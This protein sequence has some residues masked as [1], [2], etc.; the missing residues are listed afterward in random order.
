[1]P[2]SASSGDEPGSPRPPRVAL[3]GQDP[4]HRRQLGQ[5]SLL[6]ANA[7]HLDAV[8]ARC[9]PSGQQAGST[10]GS[11]RPSPRPRRGRPSHERDRAT[12]SARRCACMN[13]C[14][15]RSAISRRAPTSRRA[16]SGRPAR[17][18]R[19]PPGHR[20]GW[21]S[22]PQLLRQFPRLG[23]H[24]RGSPRSGVVPARPV[25][26]APA[27]SRAQRGRRGAAPAPTAFSRTIAPRSRSPWKS[28]ARASP[29]SSPI[30][31][32]LAPSS[33]AAAASSSSSTAS[34]LVDARAA[35]R[36]SS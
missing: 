26:S 2:S 24:R 31:S 28:S 30:R 5:S 25:R 3:A 18:G 20:L 13:G 32:S 4:D 16:A 17:R 29:A 35:S 19:H 34:R 9:V 22:G 10:R 12:R 23:Q 8:D 27:P 14:A 6:A 33:S 11:V 7:E 15:V 21:V 1:M 36:R